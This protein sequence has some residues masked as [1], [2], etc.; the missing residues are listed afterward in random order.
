MASAAEVSKG[1]FAV[2]RGVSPGR[3]SQWI[4]EGKIGAD[5]LV[6][7]GRFARI[8]VGRATAQLRERL[9]LGQLLG[10][11][12]T[13]DLTV[14]DDAGDDLA[15]DAPGRGDKPQRNTVDDQLRQA[16]LEQ[17]QRANR[18]AEREELA[19]RGVY[20][21]S[22]AASAALTSVAAGMMAVFEGGLADLASAL[23]AKYSLP[24]RE[25]LHLMRGEFRT[26]RAKA[27]EAARRKAQTLDAV[28]EHDPAADQAQ[29]AAA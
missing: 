16:R 4:R 25:I 29:P 13:T 26:I 6:G 8:H 9:D 23:A 19:E 18:Q 2:M 7:Q 11:G 20:I 14:D 3:V 21:P 1:E 10:N 24:E 15:L 12:I 17:L 22:A 28:I 27:A 5:A